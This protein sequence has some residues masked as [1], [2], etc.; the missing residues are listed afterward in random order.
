MASSSRALRGLSARAFST[1]AAV[2]EEVV[3]STPAAAAAAT[4]QT[5]PPSSL[6]QDNV[7]TPRAERKLLKTRGLTPVGSRRRRAA[8]L[9]GSRIPFEQ[10]P[11]QCF[12]EARKVLIQHR[13]EKVK[14]IEAERQKI[15]RLK[16]QTVEPQN[17]QRQQHRLN[18]MERYLDQLKIHADIDDPMV[19][20]RFEDGKGD[21]DKPIYRYL[22]DKKWRQYDRMIV[23][24]RITQ[25]NV[26]PDVLPTIDPTLNVELSFGPRDVQPGEF[27][28]SR[29]SEVPAHLNIQPYDKGERYVTIAIINPDVP[30]V[31]ADAFD[32]RCHFLAS[33]IKIS[34][35]Q[36]SVSLGKLTDDQVILPWLP[37]YTQK[38]LAYSRMSVFVLEQ[39]DGQ[40]LDAK[41]LSQ[42]Y[43]HDDF[44]LRSFVDRHVLKPVGVNMFRSRHDEGTAGVMQ[45]AGIPGGDVEFKRKKIEPLPY[46]KL[47]GSR[48]R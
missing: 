32:Y 33:N 35:T 3:A 5:P 4:T 27:V 31:E 30:N 2:A 15:A 18:S 29:V 25:M 16:A 38:G 40:I 14:D 7:F 34:P 44:I 36:T 39:K 46:K 9:S 48:Y 20:R 37:A 12:Q 10:L 26:V 45:R 47:P 17:E 13:E 11:Y 1:S 8:I 23:M 42:R 43:E 22:A 21:M 41:A 19:K 24:Q 6:A 28:D